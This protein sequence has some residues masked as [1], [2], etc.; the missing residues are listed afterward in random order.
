MVG[1]RTNYLT[2]YPGIPVR[3]PLGQM[4][5]VECRG[6]FFFFFFW[7]SIYVHLGVQNPM[8]HF[9]DVHDSNA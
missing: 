7:D 3:D 5:V 6:F 8:W 9:R 2:P 4:M 1:G